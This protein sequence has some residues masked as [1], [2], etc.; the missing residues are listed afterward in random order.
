MCSLYPRTREDDA[1]VYT[2]QL[3]TIFATKPTSAVKFGEG[4]QL[5]F[6]YL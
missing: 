4:K 2:L 1:C 3:V 6:A 5:K